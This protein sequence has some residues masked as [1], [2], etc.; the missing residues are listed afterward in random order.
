MPDM[1]PD[2]T[3]VA[4]LRLKPGVHKLLLSGV[5]GAVPVSVNIEH[6]F[7]VVSLRVIGNQVFLLPG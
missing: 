6:P 5:K 7:Q 2:H 4:R 1:Q 3:L